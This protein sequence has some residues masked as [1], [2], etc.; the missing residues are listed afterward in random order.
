MTHV[1]VNVLLDGQV[2]ILLLGADGR[3]EYFPPVLSLHDFIRGAVTM[4]D[5]M[6][7]SGALHITSEAQY[8]MDRPISPSVH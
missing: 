1:Y 8:L 4:E 3:V 6:P 5:A 2:E 7:Q